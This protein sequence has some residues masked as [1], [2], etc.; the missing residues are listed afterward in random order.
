MAAA[1]VEI[2]GAGV[3]YPRDT[4]SGRWA[5]PRSAEIEQR[6]VYR[7]AEEHES[8]D[9]SK[10]GEVDEDKRDPVG[11]ARREPGF[12]FAHGMHPVSL[13]AAGFRRNARVPAGDGHTLG[14]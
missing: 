12:V 10:A 5:G 7:D 8:G 4:E 3:P 1:S 9:G 6:C 11:Q 13:G 2:A 14:A